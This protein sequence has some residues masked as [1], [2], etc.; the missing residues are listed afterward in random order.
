[1]RS[2]SHVCVV[3]NRW[4]LEKDF[5]LHDT[6]VGIMEIREKVIFWVKRPTP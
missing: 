6:I 5:P 1:L 4:A 2:E 3:F